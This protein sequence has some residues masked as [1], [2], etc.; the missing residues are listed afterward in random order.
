MDVLNGMTRICTAFSSC[1]IIRLQREGVV[2][3]RKREYSWAGRVTLQIEEYRVL[4]ITPQIGRFLAGLEAKELLRSISTRGAVMILLQ[5]YTKSLGY[6]IGPEK[7]GTSSM[8]ATEI[9]PTTLRFV[10][11][12]FMTVSSMIVPRKG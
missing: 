6:P 9:F 8:V 7:A 4:G 5:P 11:N 10:D 1:A 12:A 3:R 2:S